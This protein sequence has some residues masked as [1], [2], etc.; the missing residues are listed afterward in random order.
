[1]THSC[2]AD[3]TL[4][5][6]VSRLKTIFDI[7]DIYD[8]FDANVESEQSKERLWMQRKMKTTTTGNFRKREFSIFGLCFCSWKWRLAK[9]KNRIHIVF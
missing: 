9:M 1:M 7:Y 3:W 2:C 8:I 5:C 6:L 4:S